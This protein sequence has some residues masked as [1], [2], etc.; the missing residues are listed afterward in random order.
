MNERDLFRAIGDVDEDLIEDANKPA[1]SK[2]KF[3]LPTAVAA[4]L[5]IAALFLLLPSFSSNTEG[6]PAMDQ[7]S[8]APQVYDNMAG[9]QQSSDF[10]FKLSWEGNSYDSAE[11]VYIPADGTAIYAELTPEELSQVFH[12]VS[13][14]NDSQGKYTIT[15]TV[16]GENHT[17]FLSP[18]D[19]QYQDLTALIEAAVNRAE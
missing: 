7:R 13:S 17:A 16:T 9:G 3:Y 4:C 6:I 11:G 8:V 12:L 2:I 14:L 18:D 10:S 15:W 19:P 5:C 1:K